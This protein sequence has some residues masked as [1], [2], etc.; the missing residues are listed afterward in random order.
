[1][2]FHTFP[3][4][5]RSVFSTISVIF[6]FVLVVAA[7]LLPTPLLADERTGAG[8]VSVMAGGYAF[9][10]EQ[11]IE[12]DA[13]GALGAGYNFTKNV[14]AEVM[15][16]YGRFD[17]EY[18]NEG[19]CCCSEDELD[20]FT[21]R[22]DGLYHFRPDKRLVPYLAAGGGA[23]FIEGDNYDDD[24]YGMVNYGGGI[25]YYLNRNLALRGDV[26][27]IYSFED[28]LNNMIGTVG[29]TYNFGGKREP[30]PLAAPEPAPVARV[31]P[32]PEPEPEPEEIPTVGIEEFEPE[33]VTKKLAINMKIEFDLDKAEVKPIYRDSLKKVADFMK[34]YPQTHAVVEGHTCNLASAAYNL[35][36]SQ[37]RANN[38]RN[39][40]IREFGI[41]PERLE[42]RG[43]G[44]TRPIADNG[45]EE[46]RQENRRVMIIVSNGI[47]VKRG[48]TPPDVP[49]FEKPETAPS[50]HAVAP[51]H[52]D[53]MA[54]TNVI[55]MTDADG[56]KGL[57]IVTTG[58]V[59]AY[60]SFQMKGPN[61]IVIDMPGQWQK[62]GQTEYTVDAPGVKGVRIGQHDDKI[63][64]VVDLAGS[65]GAE[66]RIERH[67]RG[68]LVMM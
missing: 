58:P 53:G 7:G 8:S 30:E 31:L 1:M 50:N 13:V 46:G 25:K 3:I 54:L 26:R 66:P 44:L 17:H 42:A 34:Q 49:A 41:A 52:N 15:A 48:E 68:L 60:R 11:D 64:V 19:C 6:T 24:T 47:W 51:E 21:V 28:S 63:R 38:V 14:G 59:E 27:H 40:L 18:F 65:P 20:A 56:N 12:M 57:A 37:E 61:R 62:P 4:T 23:V 67:D 35:K 36:L 45:T 32:T 10:N 29:L 9:D 2:K 55:S 22:L 5:I 39:Y 33:P 16:T 43:Y